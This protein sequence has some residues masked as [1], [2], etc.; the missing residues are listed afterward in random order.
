METDEAMEVT[1]EYAHHDY[2]EKMDAHIKELSERV[3]GAGMDYYLL[4]TDR[5]LDGALREFLTLRQGRM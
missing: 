5:P 3:R 2:R 4:A 1:P